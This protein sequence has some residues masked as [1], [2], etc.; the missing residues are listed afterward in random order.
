MSFGAG[1]RLVPEVGLD[2]GLLWIRKIND[3]SIV[4]WLKRENVGE[5]A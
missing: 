2:L 3:T 1:A 5:A 4:D